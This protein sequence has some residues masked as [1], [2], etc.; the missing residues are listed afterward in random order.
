MKIFKELV[1]RIKEEFD[2]PDDVLTEEII[3]SSLKIFLCLAERIRK[4]NRKE[5]TQSRYKEEFNLFRKLV[6]KKILESRQVRFYADELGMSTK[7]LNRITQ[8]V[9]GQAAKSYIN[10]F[11]II[12]IKRLLVN[13]SLSIKE[14]AYTTGFEE[15]TN[16][17]KYF[18][19]YAGM[20][21]S[22]FRKSFIRIIE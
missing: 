17:V 3:Q 19:K 6:K 1:L 11:L 8:D 5:E 22:E 13:T 16:F 14:I 10:D 9:M 20:N 18:K 7:K 12:E 15:A 4:E 21:P 2:A